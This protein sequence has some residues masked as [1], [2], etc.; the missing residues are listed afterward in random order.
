[1]PGIE[2]E[3]MCHQLN[4]D[5]RYRVVRQKQR[6]FAPEHNETIA[7]EVEK[8]LKARFIREVAYPEWVSNVVLVA[9][10]NGR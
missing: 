10:S 4:A 6:N 1:M 2:K 5:P 7:I 9:K 8:L 3:I